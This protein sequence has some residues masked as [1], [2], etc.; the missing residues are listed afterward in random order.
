MSRFS[1]HITRDLSL[2]TRYYND[3]H[4]ALQREARKFYETEVFP[5]AESWE[6][7]G[8]HL[9]AGITSVLTGLLKENLP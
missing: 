5:Y 9:F 7:S 4:R 8:M 3:S 6:E 2:G 1:K